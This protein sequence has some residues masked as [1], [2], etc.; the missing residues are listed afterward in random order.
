MDILNYGLL[1]GDKLTGA[2]SELGKEESTDVTS[3]WV[4]VL[5]DSLA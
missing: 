2:L 3:L 4:C 1:I 5:L